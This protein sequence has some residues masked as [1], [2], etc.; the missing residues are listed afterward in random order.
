[1]IEI[2]RYALA[3]AVAQTHL[4]PVGT[5]WIGWQSVFAFYALSGFLITRVLNERYGF[6]PRGT[7]AFVANRILRL[8]P[9]YLFTA[10]ATLIALRFLPLGEYVPTIRV[11]RDAF[12]WL[13][14]LTVLGQVGID[15]AGHVDHTKLATTSWSLSIELFCYL[16]LA[17]GVARSPSRLVALAIVGAVLLV[18][19]SL[20]CIIDPN[21]LR[22]GRYC[23]QNRYGV[24]QAGFIPFACGGLIYFHLPAI[25]AWIEKNALLLVTLLV[26]MQVATLVSPLVRFTAGPYVGVPLAAC[27][28]AFFGDRRASPTQDFLGRASYHLFIAHMSVAGV[29][30]FGF[31]APR[32]SPVMWVGTVVICLALSVALVVVER[33]VDE[34]RSVIR[35]RAASPSVAA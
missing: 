33:H 20:P 1:M 2:F 32:N 9:A 26:A 11:P 23:F 17:L 19:S 4:W 15:Y 6:T 12:E 34:Y 8:W 25:R 3:V 35:A 28:I 18:W 22:Y 29:L 30:L 13:T 10:A 14:T 21:E 27:A 5:P 24:L 31:S 7:A 16:V